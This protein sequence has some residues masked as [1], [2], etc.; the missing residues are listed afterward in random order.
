MMNVHPV[1]GRQD[2][3]LW[4]GPI[5]FFENSS[6][7]QDNSFGWSPET[8]SMRLSVQAAPV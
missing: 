8:A 6:A 1:P 5:S 4:C 3:L 2:F 7:R